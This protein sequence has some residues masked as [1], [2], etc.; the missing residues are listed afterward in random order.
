VKS[1]KRKRKGKKETEF[2][3]L[4]LLSTIEKRRGGKRKREGTEYC[5]QLAG[6]SWD[7]RGRKNARVIS[8]EDSE[9]KKGGNLDAFSGKKAAIIPWE[10]R[11]EEREQRGNMQWGG[12][13]R[14]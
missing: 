14:G 9:E 3:K 7:L 11:G 10:K 12:G 8:K 1:K 6:A 5:W 13:K 2:V 4:P